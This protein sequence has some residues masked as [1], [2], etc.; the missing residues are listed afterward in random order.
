MNSQRYVLLFAVALV[1]LLTGVFVLFRQMYSPSVE[2]SACQEIDEVVVCGEG[3]AALVN[4]EGAQHAHGE[5]NS[6]EVIHA[7]DG[8]ANEGS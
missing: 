3:A 4:G 1:A 5:A 2:R 6:G 7:D 8:H